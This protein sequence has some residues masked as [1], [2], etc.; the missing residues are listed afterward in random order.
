M[1]AESGGKAH[2]RRKAQQVH[3]PAQSVGAT[4]KVGGD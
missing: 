3:H 1:G 2:Q 4:A